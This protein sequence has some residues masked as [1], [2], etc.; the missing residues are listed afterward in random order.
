MSKEIKGTEVKEIKG[1]EV[2]T[3]EEKATAVNFTPLEDANPV[4]TFANTIPKVEV[5]KFKE[6]NLAK[7]FS[8]MYA[9]LTTAKSQASREAKGCRENGF[10]VSV[11]VAKDVM[12]KKADPTKSSAVKA[13]AQTILGKW[14][15]YLEQCQGELEEVPK[16][17]QAKANTT[18]DAISKIIYGDDTNDE[19]VLAIIDILADIKEEQ[20]A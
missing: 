19:K 9:K 14:N 4:L 7:L 15:H 5:A 3:A 13:Q 2:K 18:I 1:T 12:I 10:I 17:T 16:V 8:L 11:G 6:V 20:N